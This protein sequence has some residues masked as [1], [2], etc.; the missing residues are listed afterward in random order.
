MGKTISFI[1]SLPILPPILPHGTRL[2]KVTEQYDSYI[3]VA[4]DFINECFR[5]HYLP[6]GRVH[7][8]RCIIDGG[9][10]YEYFADFYLGGIQMYG[11]RRVQVERKRAHFY[12]LRCYL[13]LSRAQILSIPESAFTTLPTDGDFARRLDGIILPVDTI[14]LSVEH[15]I[16]GVFVC[17]HDD[18]PDWDPVAF[19]VSES[20]NIP[21]NPAVLP[22]PEVVID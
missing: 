6:S 7:L 14:A 8:G 9:E 10:R 21:H 11:F 19:M 2:P 16:D 5:Y 17:F 3:S 15:A 4:K 1:M 18:C 20:G 22:T 13:N 12:E